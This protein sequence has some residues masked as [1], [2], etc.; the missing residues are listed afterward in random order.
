MRAYALI[1][2]TLSRGRFVRKVRLVH[3]PEVANALGDG[4]HALMSV[5]NRG[6]TVRL[7]DLRAAGMALTKA[8]SAL[9]NHIDELQG[10]LSQDT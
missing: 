1:A 4:G 9:R 10:W 7:A 2:D 3:M 5:E 8:A 6:D